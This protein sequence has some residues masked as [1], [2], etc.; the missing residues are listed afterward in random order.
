MLRA[1]ALAATLSHPA[2]AQVLG[3]PAVIKALMIDYGLTVEQDVDAAGDPRL[4]SRIEGLYFS[5]YFYDCADRLCQ[6]I[7]FSS[8][9]DTDTP[10]DPGAL[11]RWNSDYRFAKVYLDDEG[12]A[13]V[14]MDVNLDG[15]G[16]GRKNFDDTLD[17]WR[18]VL[19][20]FRSYI[21]W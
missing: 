10:L 16:V 17:I 7:Q 1:L 5:V 21:N 6:S 19:T 4:T 2:A 3:D 18:A 8:A 11:N 20:A 13:R 15:D 9:F 14:E 12:D